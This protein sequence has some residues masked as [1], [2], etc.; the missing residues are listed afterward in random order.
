MEMCRAVNFQIPTDFAIISA[1]GHVDSLAECN[2]TLTHGAEDGEGLINAACDY[3]ACSMDRA[4]G[5][6]LTIPI[7]VGGVV[8][9]GSTD[10][11]AVDDPTVARAIAFMNSYFRNPIQ[12]ADIVAHVGRSRRWLERAFQR[13]M[14]LTLHDYLT[15]R[16]VK[17]A[18]RRIRKTPDKSL[19]KIA[20]AAGFGNL[21]TFNRSFA[22]ATG[23]SPFRWRQR[24]EGK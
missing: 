19:A 20:I 23:M 5:R 7:P 8:L 13:A 9:G 12:I 3:L 14:N 2:P 16:R 11:T 4:D 1:T 18:Q 24:C 10:A 17:D 21:P 15:D 22:A 6:I